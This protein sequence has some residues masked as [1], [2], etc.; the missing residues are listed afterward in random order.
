M[1]FLARS[2]ASRDYQ[3]PAVAAQGGAVQPPGAA[4]QP[5][6]EVPLQVVAARLVVAVPLR[7]VAV[8][9]AAEALQVAAALLAAGAEVGAEAEAAPRQQ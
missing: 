5:V 7:V 4:G 8:R 1:A 3:E 6:V 9:R 2:Q